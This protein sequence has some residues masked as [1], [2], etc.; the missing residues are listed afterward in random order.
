MLAFLPTRQQ[1]VW[2][3]PAVLNFSMGG[4]GAGFFLVLTL[5]QRW[6][7]I[8]RTLRPWMVVGPLLLIL[9][10]AALALEAGRPF[11]AR[12]VLRHLKR[13]W[14]SRE[15]LAAL[16]FVPAVLVVWWTDSAVAWSLAAIAGSGF[17]VCQGFILYAARA[18]PAWNQPVIPLV[19]VTTAFAS[20]IGVTLVMLALSGAGFPSPAW[21]WISLMTIAMAADAC[22]WG[23]YLFGSGSEPFRQ[24]TDVLRRRSAIVG[25]IVIL[26]LLPAFL[27]LWYGIAGQTALQ[28]H[29]SWRTAILLSGLALFVANLFQKSSLIRRCGHLRAVGIPWKPPVSPATA[30]TTR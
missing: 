25:H 10:F 14:M 24:S 29:A 21:P 5:M 27:L 23:A 15:S 16:I 12:F 6:S 7:G 3:W 18:V 4:A 20:G 30:A 11:R 28:D 17:I 26:R 8:P 1:P 22:V 19:F 2:G 9:G 13:S